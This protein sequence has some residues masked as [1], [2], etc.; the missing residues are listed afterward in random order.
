MKKCTG[1]LSVQY[2][3]TK[4]WCFIYLVIFFLI[5]GAALSVQ[6]QTLFNVA[7]QN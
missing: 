2:F 5:F 3:N 6:S 7:L 4:G 1:L